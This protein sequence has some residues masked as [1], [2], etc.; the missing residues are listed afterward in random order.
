[1]DTVVCGLCCHDLCGVV[2]VVLSCV[3]Y[4]FVW[5]NY[6]VVLCCSAVDLLCAVLGGDVVQ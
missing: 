2:W 1:M 5:C 6:C 4:C 3:V